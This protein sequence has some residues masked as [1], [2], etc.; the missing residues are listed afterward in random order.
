MP[1]GCVASIKQLAKIR[2]K[3]WQSNA[4]NQNQQFCNME[5]GGNWWTAEMFL[6][7]LLLLQTHCYFHFQLKQLDC[8]QRRNQNFAMTLVRKSL[9]MY[10]EVMFLPNYYVFL[11]LDYIKIFWTRFHSYLIYWCCTVMPPWVLSCLCFIFAFVPFIKHA[12][13]CKAFIFA[14]LAQFPFYFIFFVS[15]SCNFFG[16]IFME[17][18]NM[19]IKLWSYILAWIIRTWISAPFTPHA[20]YSVA[21]CLGSV[22]LHH[23]YYKKSLIMYLLPRIKFNTSKLLQK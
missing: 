23:L 17:L 15:I 14:L 4:Q 18:L 12:N 10:A 22:L 2:S 8:P 20:N 21:Q 19:M 1:S 6:D 7:W 3:E 5:A 11:I 9:K 16:V 13:S